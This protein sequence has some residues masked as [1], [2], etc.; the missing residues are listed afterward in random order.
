MALPP[1][2]PLAA[3][4]P[5][6]LIQVRAW[7]TQSRTTSS[8]EPSPGSRVNRAMRIAIS[9]ILL[10]LFSA[11][12]EVPVPRSDTPAPQPAALN[13]S[14]AEPPVSPA[15]DVNT[16]VARLRAALMEEVPSVITDESERE[17]AWIDQ[18]KAAMAAGGPTID[19]PQ[20]LVVVDRNPSVQ[21][22]RIV[23]ARP[24]GVWESLGGSKA[25]TGQTD[26]RDYYLTPLG[27]F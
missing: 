14:T 21:Q 25:S 11:C 24:N 10:I 3:L 2:N 1:C 19:R 8:N 13:R 17:R 12:T 22:M 23:L 20:F 15:L 27:V 4:Q 6:T 26:R 5:A 9:V 18:A 7:R 16:E